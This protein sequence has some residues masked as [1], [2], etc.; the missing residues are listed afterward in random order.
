[1]I[2]IFVVLSIFL[3]MTAIVIFGGNRFFEKDNYVI[4]YFEG[5]LQ[6]LSIGAPVTYRGVT[7]GQVKDIKI[8]IQP[9]GEANQKLVI[10]VLIALHAGQTL[11]ID[12]P[13]QNLTHGIDPFLKSMC[14]EGL[15]AKL[16]LVSL[17]TGKRYI[18]L[19]F[20]ENTTPEYRD[21]MGEY[22]EIPTLPSEMEQF[23]KMMN[24][25][26]LGELYQKVMRTFS[27][28]EELTG[29]LAKTLNHDKTQHLVDELLVATVNLN[30]ILQQVDTSLPPIL[31]KIDTGL[32]SING[33][34]SNA[35]KAV[36]SLNTQLPLIMDTMESTL[37]SIDTAVHQANAL[38][39]QA[40]TILK[41]SSPLYYKL[42]T[43]IEQLEDT[44]ISI[45]KLSD[46]IHRN[47]NTLIF[48]LQESG[49]T[50]HD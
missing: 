47:P 45:E 41:P 6:G 31:H 13:H 38:L 3:L 33:L 30:Q 50:K 39:I 40:E 27:S 44:A 12:N 26:D 7:V 46:Y 37:G 11:I 34:T 15:R 5:S 28:L 42:T 2:G 8:H 1:M 23:N 49:E 29:G 16:K 22:F 48:G 32:D 36:N 17:V 25:I 10:P 43:T 20:Y 35:D 18:D 9:D 14:E 19:A 21:T 4:T 24:T